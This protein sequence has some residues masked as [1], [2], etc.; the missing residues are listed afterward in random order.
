M[1]EIPYEC[2]PIW[3][4][5]HMNVIPYECD[6]IWMR[7]HM[8]EIPY[9]CD[10][11]W[12]KK[13]HSKCTGLYAQQ[14]AD[15]SPHLQKFWKK[16]EVKNSEEEWLQVVHRSST[17][18]SGVAVEMYGVYTVYVTWHV[19]SNVTSHVMS[20]PVPNTH[21]QTHGSM[22]YLRHVTSIYVTSHPSTSRHIHIRHVTSSP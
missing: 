3:M 4:R 16:W 22:C 20:H 5:S 7:S 18:S 1:N 13:W 11:I 15:F 6:P 9:E 14:S 21:T 12:M 10:P 2:D 17:Y 19:T 8:N